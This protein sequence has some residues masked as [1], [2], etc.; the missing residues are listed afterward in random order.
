MSSQDDRLIGKYVGT[1]TFT[2]RAL[3]C[4]QPFLEL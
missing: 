4:R 2:L 3:H 1:I